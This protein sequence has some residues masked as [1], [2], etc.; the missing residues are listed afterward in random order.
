[1]EKLLSPDESAEIA[2]LY[3]HEEHF[4]SHVVMARHGFGKGEYRYCKYPLPPLLHGLRTAL[5]RHFSGAANEWNERMRMNQRYPETHAE[6]LKISQAAGQ[7]RP[8]PLL[9][10]L[11]STIPLMVDSTPDQNSSE[12][13][14]L[15]SSGMLSSVTERTTPGS[16]DSMRKVQ[17]R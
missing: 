17:F 6:F 13:A 14:R 10:V 12:R 4:R 1:M 3:P 7:T 16:P 15:V 11:A 2:A 5:Y 8:T 9:L